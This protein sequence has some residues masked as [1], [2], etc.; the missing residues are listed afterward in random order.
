MENK[1][2]DLQNRIIELKGEIVTLSNL[3]KQL[4]NKEPEKNF[5]IKDRLQLIKKLENELKELN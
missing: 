4:G 2:E 1:K 3:C 5:M